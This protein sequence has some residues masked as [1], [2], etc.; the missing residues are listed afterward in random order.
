MGDESIFE[1]A[2]KLCILKDGEL[3]CTESFY[4]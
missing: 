3:V 4:M 2:T 1:I